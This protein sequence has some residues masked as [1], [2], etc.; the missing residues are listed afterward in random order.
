MVGH[1][2][3]DDLPVLPLGL[4]LFPDHVFHLVPPDRRGGLVRIDLG[5]GFEGHA[6]VVG[7]ILIL[8]FLTGLALALLHDLLGTLGLLGGGVFHAGQGVGLLAGELG[9]LGVPALGL[10]R[11]LGGVGIAGL[12]NPHPRRHGGGVEV[13][14]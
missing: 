4:G 7:P 11:G 5:G 12:L 2:L 6:G 9:G 8:A 10:A 13:V 3:A 14:A 1:A